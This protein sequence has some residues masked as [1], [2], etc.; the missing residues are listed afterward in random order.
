MP[1]ASSVPA[2]LDAAL[3]SLACARLG[4]LGTMAADKA[5]IAWDAATEGWDSAGRDRVRAAAA[6]L[7][8][9]GNTEDR[10]RNHFIKAFRARHGADRAGWTEDLR[11]EFE[12]GIAA[13][14][15]RKQEELE[16]VIAELSRG[17]PVKECTE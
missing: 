1:P 8:A 12:S 5:E 15:R 14:T 4:A 17:L 10:A 9:L 11:R 2:A 7:D 16:R 3:Q 13:H 6:S